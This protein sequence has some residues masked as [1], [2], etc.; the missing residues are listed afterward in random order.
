MLIEEEKRGIDPNYNKKLDSHI[1]A[2]PKAV[3]LDILFIIKDMLTTNSETEPT[4]KEFYEKLE[5]LR[6][7]NSEFGD[8]LEQYDWKKQDTLQKQC[9]VNIETMF[10]KRT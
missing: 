1:S 10:K 3:I 6:D 7:M 5:T 9:G 2:Q 4:R 8:D